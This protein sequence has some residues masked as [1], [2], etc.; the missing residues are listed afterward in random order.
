MNTL[1]QGNMPG[2]LP[3]QFHLNKLKS[4]MDE[5]MLRRTSFNQQKYLYTE[6]QKLECVINR[7]NI[8]SAKLIEE[9]FAD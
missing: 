3:L 6:I 2:I 8:N 1:P 4:R 7:L 9:R 5:E